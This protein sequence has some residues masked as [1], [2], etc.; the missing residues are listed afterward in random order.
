MCWVLLSGDA[1]GIYTDIKIIK[2]LRSTWSTCALPVRGVLTVVSRL[3][4]LYL[5]ELHCTVLV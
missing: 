1:D 2:V 3:T 4:K 5:S